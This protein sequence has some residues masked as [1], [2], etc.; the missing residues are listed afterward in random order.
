MSV[1]LETDNPGS[2]RTAQCVILTAVCNH[3]KFQERLD[4]N[5]GMSIFFQTHHLS[6]DFDQIRAILTALHVYDQLND[7]WCLGQHRIW[8][9]MAVKWSNVSPEMFCLDLL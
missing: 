5:V 8:K 1:D 9:Q 4:A 7:C 6:Y 3:S 2:K